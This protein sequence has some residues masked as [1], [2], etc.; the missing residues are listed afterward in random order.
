MERSLRTRR[1]HLA[2][3]PLPVGLF[4]LVASPVHI[5][6]A[7]LARRLSAVVESAGAVLWQPW[8]AQA[9]ASPGLI[10]PRLKQCRPLRGQITL[11]ERWGMSRG[12]LLDGNVG[13]IVG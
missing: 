10:R 6:R 11:F 13:G 7:L 5:G 9:S 8:M 4:R 2:E 3:L 12:C 1:D